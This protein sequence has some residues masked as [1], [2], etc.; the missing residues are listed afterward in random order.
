MHASRTVGPPSL[1]ATRPPTRSVRA[2]GVKV[3]SRPARAPAANTSAAADGARA[4]LHRRNLL[5]LAAAA[6][7]AAAAPPRPA[8]A[9]EDTAGPTVFF[10]S[11]SKGYSLTPPPAW[12][13]SSKAGA[14]AFW[15]DPATR[16][17]TL[18]VVVLPVRLASLAG[19]GTL[20]EVAQ[21]LLAAEKAKDGTLG[22]ALTAA[23]EVSGRGG[24]GQG[25]SPSASPPPPAAPASPSSSSATPAYRYEYVLA[26]SRAFKTVVTAVAVARGNLFIVTG[27][28]PCAGGAAAAAAA[29]GEG[30]LN[31]E[32]AAAGACTAPLL[33]VVRAAVDS[34][35]VQA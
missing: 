14:D 3:A 30:G 18:G 13:P 10:T 8:A 19:S 35:T 12:A 27:M 5:F 15:S 25:P 23:A 1:S 2:H 9:A 33:G 22:V 4:L 29:A 34:F 28:A 7:T 11:P 17:A 20:G 16:G 24:A 21:R 32:G 31:V 6:A 26:T